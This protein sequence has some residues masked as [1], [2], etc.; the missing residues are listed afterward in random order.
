[1]AD[2]VETISYINLGDGLEHPIVDLNAFDNVEYNSQTKRINF[3]HG[4]TVLKYIDATDF[5]K[6]GMVNDVQITTPESGDNAGQVCL[7]VTFNMDAGKEDIEIPLTSIFNPNNYYTKTQIDQSVVKYS[8]TQNLNDAHKSQA[9]QNIGAGTLTGITF[10][11]SEASVSNGIASITA[12]IPEGLPA[13]SSSDNGKVLQVVNGQ[14]TLVSP[15]GIYSGNSVP[16]NSTGNN[17]DLYLQ[18]N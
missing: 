12:N 10:N 6:D 18:T 13:V 1:M 16:S 4:N 8:T 2:N 17:G 7:L 9:R 3:K 15:V 11:G 5:I 14:W